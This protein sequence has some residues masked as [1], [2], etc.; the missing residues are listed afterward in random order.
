MS[1]INEYKDPMSGKVNH[2]AKGSIKFISIKPVKNADPDGVKRTHIPARNGQPAKVIE[3]T[4]TI[5]FLMQEVDDNNNVIDPQSQGEWI[6]MGEKKL[7]AS[8]TDK[9]QVKLDSGYKDILPGMVASFPLKVSTNGDKTYVNG[10]LS[11]K[12]FNILDESKAGQPAPRQ[13]PQQSAQGQ[14]SGGGVKVYGEITAIAGNLATVNDEKNG[15][16]N[17]VLS[18]E[19][20]AQVQ[21]GGRLTA[22][23]NLADGTILNGFKAYGPVGQGTGSGGKKS[24]GNYDPIGVACGHGI[25]G[26]K[27]LMGA[28]YKVKDELETVKAIHRATVDM[29]AFVA[30]RTGKD[31]ESNAVGASAGNAILVACSRFNAK[32]EVT[33][34]TILESA[35]NVY[36]TLSEPFY[37]FLTNDGKPADQTPPQTSQEPLSGTVDVPPMDAYEPPMDFDDDIPFAPIGLQYGRNF[38]HCI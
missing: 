35:K 24:G 10:S 4:H 19:Q 25:N 34:A 7:H 20:L 26:L 31:V 37:E 12:T 28:G 32:S 18:D 9:V 1:V 27:E 15:P 8:H 5:S 6:G 2:F 23:V 11:G 3:S 36:V 29:K 30:E 22:F 13:Q 17:V 33:E 21:V 16:G 14:Q 38:I